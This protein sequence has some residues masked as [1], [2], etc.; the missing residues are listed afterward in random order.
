MSQRIWFITVS[1]PGEL[2]PIS[3]AGVRRRR[4]SKESAAH[5]RGVA[6]PVRTESARERLAN[7]CKAC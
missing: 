7:P 2:G 3:R 1:S 5:L 6:I 4:S